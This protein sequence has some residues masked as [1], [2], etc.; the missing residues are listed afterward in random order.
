MNFTTDV[1]EV[2]RVLGIGKGLEQSKEAATELDQRLFK[3][4]AYSVT[5]FAAHVEKTYINTYRSFEIII[6]TL[7]M[8]AESPDK[9]VSEVAKSLCSKLLSTK[10]VGTL[11]G[12]IDVYRII[13]TASCELQNVE[14]FPWE[15]VS[16]LNDVIKKLKSMSETLKIL[17][18]DVNC[19]YHTQWC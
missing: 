14:Q 12:C 19:V 5:R 16:V 4:Q 15:V 3:L 18:T 13:A 1:G 8:R 9:K 2:T 11:L 17:P 6:R 7:Q 10:F